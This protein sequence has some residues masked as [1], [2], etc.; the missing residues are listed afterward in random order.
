M[1]QRAKPLILSVRLLTAVA[2]ASLMSGCVLAPVEPMNMHVSTQTPYAGVY[3]GVAGYPAAYYPSYGYPMPYGANFQPGAHPGLPVAGGPLYMPA[4]MLN[5]RMTGVATPWHSGVTS[6][7][8][9]PFY[10]GQSAPVMPQLTVAS[11]AMPSR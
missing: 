7:N 5:W 10:A 2:A 11:P 9:Y 1:K 6:P 4:A 8:P 3:P